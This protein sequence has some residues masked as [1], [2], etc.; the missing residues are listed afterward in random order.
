MTLH[1]SDVVRA[2]QIL[3]YIC[4]EG[5]YDCFSG[6]CPLQDMCRGYKRD[7]DTTPF[8]VLDDP[9]TTIKLTELM[10]EHRLITKG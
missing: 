10:R 7:D 6:E 1:E 2:M 5:G 3:H 9:D 4:D 8:A